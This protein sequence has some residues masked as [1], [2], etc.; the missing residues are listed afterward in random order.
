MLH[1]S[2]NLSNQVFPISWFYKI[3]KNISKHNNKIL[4]TPFG[5]NSQIILIG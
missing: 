2:A 5:K 1:I 3:V 4:G